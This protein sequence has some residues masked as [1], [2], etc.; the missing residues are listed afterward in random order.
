MAAQRTAPSSAGVRAS[1]SPG[2]GMRARLT[3]DADAWPAP[4]TLADV[5]RSTIATMITCEVGDCPEGAT[6][7]VLLALTD[8]SEETWQ[9]CREHDR[10]LKL[11]AVRSREQAPEP[12]GQPP[13]VQCR[14]CEQVLDD[15]SPPCPG[16]GSYDR[17][18]TASD[19]ATAHESVRVRAKHPE[20]GGWI[21][22]VSAGDNY[23]RDLAAWGH[24]TLTLDRR[25]NAYCEVIEL[26]EGSRIVSTASLT[27]HQS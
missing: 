19:T 27:D 26:Y 2:L 1:G 14:D 3:A 6:H 7:T 11:T 25:E 23:T 16:C 24:R 20:K 8:Q 5:N 13:R 15:A 12:V 18:I 21:V 22:Q 10:W 9:V 17:L 4:S